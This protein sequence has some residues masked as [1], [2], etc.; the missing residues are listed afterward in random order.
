MERNGGCD[1]GCGDGGVD[2]HVVLGFE[3]VGE[4]C[5]GVGETLHAFGQRKPNAHN[6][7]ATS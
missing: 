2:P 7:A 3:D 4:A 5:E 6:R 1:H